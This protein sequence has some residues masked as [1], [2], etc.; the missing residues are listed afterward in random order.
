VDPSPLLLLPFIGLL[1]QPWMIDGDDC[2]AVGGMNEWQGKQPPNRH[3]DDY[4]IKHINSVAFSSQSSYTDWVTGTCWRNLVPTFGDRGVSCGQRGGSP[5]AVNLS[6]LDRSGYFCF[7]Y[8]LIYPH[9]GWV[10]P[11]PD[12][13]LLRKFGS[14]GNRT[15]YLWLSSQEL[16]PSDHSGGRRSHDHLPKSGL[17]EA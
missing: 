15:R 7:K 10:D 16:W 5:T 1:Y 13:L 17:G 6:F 4:A 12:P 8:L 14:A 11:V 3:N 9:K 2:G